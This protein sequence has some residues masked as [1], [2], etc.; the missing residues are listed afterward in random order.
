MPKLVCM[1]GMTKGDEYNLPEGETFMGRSESNDICIFDNMASRVHCKLINEGG[2]ITLIDNNSTNGLMVNDTVVEGSVKLSIGDVIR[3]GYTKYELTNV[4]P[5]A[6]HTK[7]NNLLK[8]V[9]NNRVT[10]GMG[11]MQK[12]KLK[13]DL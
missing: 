9:R 13:I 12:T 6:T 1:S 11:S 10:P 7:M 2:E 8:N 4:D 3:V 5:N